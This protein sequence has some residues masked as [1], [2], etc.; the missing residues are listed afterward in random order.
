VKL[1]SLVKKIDEESNGYAFQMPSD[2]GTFREL[3]EWVD[4]ERKCCPFMD[5]SLTIGD[6]TKPL[7]LRINGEGKVKEFLKNSPLVELSQKKK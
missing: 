2:S 3:S 4:L 5:F 1:F 7:T 6:E